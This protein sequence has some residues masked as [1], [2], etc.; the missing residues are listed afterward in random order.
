MKG[1][2]LKF[3]DTNQFLIQYQNISKNIVNYK[4]INNTMQDFTSIVEYFEEITN[5][6]SEDY[7]KK[8]LSGNKII[9]QFLH[10][11]K[12]RQSL[13]VLRYAPVLATMI[14]ETGNIQINDKVYN[15]FNEEDLKSVLNFLPDSVEN[16]YYK[17]GDYE[18]TEAPSEDLVR[19]F[20]VNNVFPFTFPG[21]P[22]KVFYDKIEGHSIIIQAWKGMAGVSFSRKI[23]GGVGGEVGIYRGHKPTFFDLIRNALIK[24]FWPPDYK[25]KWNI[26]YTLYN[27]RDEVF[28]TAKHDGIWWLHKWMQT[29]SYIRY[30]KDNHLSKCPDSYRM[31]FT[32]Q[33]KPF[34]W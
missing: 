17:E 11:K 20:P 24:A 14:N 30:K 4:A 21:Y 1:S 15:L 8:Y 3:D 13:A 19:F 29:D 31:E 7:Q 2:Y 32:V 26:E 22:T 34:S 33:G 27:E 18:F 6:E 12:G 28:F 23:P 5:M 10:G 9:S 16:E 25:H